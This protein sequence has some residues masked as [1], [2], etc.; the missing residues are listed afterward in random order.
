MAENENPNDEFTD[1]ELQQM[2][3]DDLR[4]LA[5]EAREGQPFE[6]VEEPEHGYDIPAPAEDPAGRQTHDCEFVFAVYYDREAGAIAVAKTA[7]V[8]I[9]DQEANEIRLVPRREASTDD[10]WRS[11]A[12]VAKDIESS[13]TASQTA[14]AMLQVTQAMQQQMAVQRQQQQEAAKNAQRISEAARRGGMQ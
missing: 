1:E 9:E 13:Q 4:R 12:E 3:Q 7:L 2:P 10:M 11:A 8:V 5:A 6:P 14:N